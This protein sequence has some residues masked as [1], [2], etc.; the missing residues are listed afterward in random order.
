MRSTGL[1]WLEAHGDA[2]FRFAARRVRDRAVA[3]DLVQDTLL[4]AIQDAPALAAAVSERAWLLGI[5]RHKLLDYFRR[6]AREQWVWDSSIESTDGDAVFTDGGQ[7]HA[8]PRDWDTPERALERAELV[9]AFEL[10]ID[11]LPVSWRTPF[12][13]REVDGLESDALAES[14]GTTKNHV[15]VMLSRARQRMRQCL[16][17]YFS[18]T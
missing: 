7:W 3:E 18:R 1:R 6:R 8:P 11:D 4:A 5:L 2:L 16:E 17:L 14:L 13:L 9:T 15:W 10:C 12:V